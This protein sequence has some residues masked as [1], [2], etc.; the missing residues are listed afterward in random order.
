MTDSASNVPHLPTE[1]I[2]HIIDLV[3]ELMYEE[4]DFESTYEHRGLKGE[5]TSGEIEDQK[6]ALEAILENFGT[7][8][9]CFGSIT[10]GDL[11]TD[12]RTKWDSFN[13]K[14][15]SVSIPFSFYVDTLLTRRI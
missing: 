14:H 11:I 13:A 8:K 1:V 15:R 5:P 2:E 3:K 10:D 7:S 6:K 4:Q 9:G 12:L